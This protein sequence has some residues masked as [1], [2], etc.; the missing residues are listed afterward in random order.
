MNIE[1]MDDERLDDLN[2]K[3]LKILQ[4]KMDFVLEWIVY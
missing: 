3:N 2:C 1:I 4:K